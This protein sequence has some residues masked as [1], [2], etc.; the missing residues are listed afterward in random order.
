MFKRV[1][2]VFFFLRFNKSQ[3]TFLLCLNFP[4]V[5]YVPCAAIT[6]LK[7]EKNL[8]QQR[9]AKNRMSIQF[10]SSTVISSFQFVSSS[11]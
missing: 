8:P 3:Q 5:F 10:F 7:E 1:A 6:R 2:N 9:L 4:S 11:L